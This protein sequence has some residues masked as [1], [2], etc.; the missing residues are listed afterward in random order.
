VRA[1]HGLDVGDTLGTYRVEA[2]IGRGGMGTVFLAEH[3]QLGRKVALKVLPPNLAEDPAFRERFIRESQLAASLDHPSIIPIY[4][5]DEREGIL[6]IAMRYVEGTDLR[7]LLKAEAPLAPQQALRLL[8]PVSA[9]LDAAHAKGLVHRDVKPANILIEQASGRVFVSDFGLAK[10][11]SAVGMA[12]TGSFLGT[13]DY[14]APEQIEGK[15]VD[16]RTD[17]YSLGCV[18][19]EC[20]TGQPPFVKDS[21]VAVIQAHLADPPPAV[22]TLRPEL[23]SALDGVLAT[24]MAKNPPVRYE[25]CGELTDALDDALADKGTAATVPL[26]PGALTVAEHTLASPAEPV[27]S[28]GGTAVARPPRSWR[29]PALAA[30][31]AVLL[32]AGA[33]AALLVAARNGGDGK[34]TTTPPTQQAAAA[35]RVATR[36]RRDLVPPQRTLDIRVRNLSA[37]PASFQAMETAALAVERSVLRMQGWMTSAPL[38]HTARDRA[39][40]QGLSTALSAHSAYAKSITTLAP[41]ATSLSRRQANAIIARA[42]TADD[43][44]LRLSGI[45]SLIPAMPISRGDHLHLLSLVPRPRPGAVPRP[46]PPA[47]S[48]PATTGTPSS[49]FRGSYF[50]IDYPSGWQV[51]TAEALKTD[52]YDTTIRSPA[53]PSLLLRVDVKRNAPANLD[54]GASPVVA[55]LARQPRYRSLAYR[56]TTFNGHDAIYWE[57][58]V[59]ESGRLLHKVDIFFLDNS[60]NGFGVLTQAPADAWA[61]WVPTFNSVLQSVAP[62][63][64]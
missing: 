38:A 41:G 47:V 24:A 57:F 2:L 25:A 50:S 4:D 46:S 49:T 23:P 8:E 40:R 5:A 30:G 54:A 26:R 62:A 61:S 64:G 39:V 51:E 22:T 12:R 36:L 20:L 42:Q 34:A 16:A 63:S 52:Y 56:H 43:A 58:L 13:V 15:P 55:A 18:L 53:D 11:V 21:E 29:K 19:F 1:A 48:P 27:P 14:C 31:A 28:P 35:P 45:S 6:Y 17:V 59:S 37:A 44:Y 60:G 10:L 3:L 33:A 9:G 32:M 7:R